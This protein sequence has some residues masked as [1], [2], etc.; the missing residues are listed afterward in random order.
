MA[1][2]L[3]QFPFCQS[4]ASYILVLLWVWVQVVG[5]I[6]SY[7]LRKTKNTHEFTPTPLA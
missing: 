4:L 1:S 2:L 7:N 5:L 6:G 3:A